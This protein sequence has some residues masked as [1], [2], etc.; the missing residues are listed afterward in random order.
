MSVPCSL[1]ILTILKFEYRLAECSD[2]CLGLF[3][4]ESDAHPSKNEH[5]TLIAHV[6]ATR[7]ATSVVTEE[8]MGI[9][10]NNPKGTYAAVHSLAVSP[11]YQGKGIG[12]TLMRMYIEYVKE[13]KEKLNLSGIAIIAHGHLIKFY[14]SLG[15]KNEGKSECQFGGGGWYDMVSAL[16]G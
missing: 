8:S 2:L 11:D 13:Q 9:T 5:D 3:V 7:I 14:E 15:F 12:R 16:V 6:I 10:G 1:P 4:A